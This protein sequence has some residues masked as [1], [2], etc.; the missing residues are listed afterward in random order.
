M[1]IIFY[2]Q[3]SDKHLDI[4]IYQV[5]YKNCSQKI[6]TQFI[7]YILRNPAHQLEKHGFEK[8]ALRVLG[9]NKKKVGVSVF[10]DL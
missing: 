3:Q 1:H 5:M 2:S 7:E 9:C 10:E 8:N 4:N 6:S